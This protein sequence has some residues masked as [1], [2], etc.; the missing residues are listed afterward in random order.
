MGD[1]E[2]NFGGALLKRPHARRLRGNQRVLKQAHS[3]TSVFVG[4]ALCRR[5]AVC[6]PPTSLDLSG[7]SYFYVSEAKPSKTVQKSDERK[8]CKQ[9][10]MN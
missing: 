8:P 4:S 5:L 1:T 10:P 7:I 9:K 2:A 3:R 6:R